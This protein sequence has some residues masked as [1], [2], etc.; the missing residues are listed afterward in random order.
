MRLNVNICWLVI[1]Y[2]K[3]IYV[4]WW[5]Y[6]LSAYM[7]I[8]DYIRWVHICWWWIYMLCAYM[9]L[10]KSFTGDWWW[11]V[12][13]CMY[14]NIIDV[15]LWN[16][17]KYVLLLLSPS[18]HTLLLLAFISNCCWMLRYSL[19]G[20]IW[21]VYMHRGDGL[22]DEWNLVPHIVESV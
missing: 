19:F 17:M 9:L 20:V 1:I 5:L 14:W 12:G 15:D 10:V 4:D 16:Y 22:G 7:L 11:I 21:C 2:V 6:M 3:C 8:G 18:S 13:V